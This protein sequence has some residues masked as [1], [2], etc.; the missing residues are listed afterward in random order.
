MIR[1]T[2]HDTLIRRS[3]SYRRDAAAIADVKRHDQLRIFIRYCVFDLRQRNLLFEGADVDCGGRVTIWSI[4]NAIEATLIREWWSGKCGSH[5][6]GIRTGIQRR[7]ACE[8]RVGQRRTAVVSKRP[9]T[10]IAD[11]KLVA[12]DAVN[13]TALIANSD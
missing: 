5:D 1:I 7:T 4:S 3:R 2:R 13:E 9:Q 11:P 6:E 10:G 12:V 8:Q